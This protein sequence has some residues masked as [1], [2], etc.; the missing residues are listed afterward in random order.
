MR[1]CARKREVVIE[2]L[3][4][5]QPVVTLNGAL[6][7]RGQRFLPSSQGASVAIKFSPFLPSE[8]N[9]TADKFSWAIVPSSIA[10][11]SCKRAA[12]NRVRSSVPPPRPHVWSH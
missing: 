5:L 8:P 4:L 6:L 9:L 1:K 12:W 2:L 7:K 11:G 10:K 3:M